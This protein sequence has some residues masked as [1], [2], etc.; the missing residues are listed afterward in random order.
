MSCQFGRMTHRIKQFGAAWCSHFSRYFGLVRQSSVRCGIIFFWRISQKN[1]V[2][3]LHGHSVGGMIEVEGLAMFSREFELPFAPFVIIAFLIVCSLCVL[4]DTAA[5][6]EPLP[7]LLD[8][9]V[10]APLTPAIR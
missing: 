10:T 1:E 2:S 6:Y 3:G 8:S 7:P 5:R 9:G 4:V